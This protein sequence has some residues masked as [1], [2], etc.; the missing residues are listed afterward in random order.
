MYYFNLFLQLAITHIRKSTNNPHLH[1][2]TMAPVSK[3]KKTYY[4]I[5]P[6]ILKCKIC[7]TCLKLGLVLSG[8]TFDQQLILCSKREDTSSGHCD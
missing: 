8:L 2:F 3:K 6:Y 4:S 1:S 7:R 5:E